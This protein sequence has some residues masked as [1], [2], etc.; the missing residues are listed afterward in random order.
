MSI[1]N[2]VIGCA[3]ALAVSFGAGVYVGYKHSKDMEYAAGKVVKESAQIDR[4]LKTWTPIIVERL[5]DA[6]DDIK[7]EI[8]LDMREQEAEK[9]QKE[10]LD[11]LDKLIEDYE[12]RK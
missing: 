3:A 5:V 8:I 12:L 11:K 7:R 4:N 6:T 2:Y 1:K 10:F 9:K